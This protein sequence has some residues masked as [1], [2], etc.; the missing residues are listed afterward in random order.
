MGWFNLH[1][2]LGWGQVQCCFIPWVGEITIAM[3]QWLCQPSYGFPHSSIS[4][5]RKWV[6]Q[7]VASQ[8]NPLDTAVIENA[9]QNLTCFLFF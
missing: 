2:P 4:L 3:S 8:I 9:Y 5:D 1:F 6:D 7:E